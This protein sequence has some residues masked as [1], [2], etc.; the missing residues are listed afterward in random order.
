MAWT[1]DDLGRLSTAEI[2]DITLSSGPRK[3]LQ[4]DIGNEGFWSDVGFHALAHSFSRAPTHRLN[5]LMG[6]GK[7]VG[8]GLPNLNGGAYKSQFENRIRDAV[9][10]G[11]TVD[12][13]VEPVYFSPNSSARPDQFRT[14]YRVNGGDW[15]EHT[16]DN[17]SCTSRPTA[18]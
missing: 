18:P 1:T 5:V 4:T 6:N 15:I 11:D 14:S 16:F 13:M 8:N 10:R 7:R 17:V 2:Y 3:A 9:R 12:A